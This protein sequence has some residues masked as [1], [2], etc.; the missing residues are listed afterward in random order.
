[1]GRM[2]TW[3]LRATGRSWIACRP[4][5]P[6]WGGL[7]IGVE[8]SEPKTPPLVIVN[9]PPSSSSGLSLLLGAR[10]DEVGDRLL[11]FGEAQPLGV[12]Q[13]GHDEALR[14]AD[15]D[16]DVVVVAIDDVVAADFGVER[17]LAL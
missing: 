4:R 16:A 9:V 8:R 13:H 5:T 14:A 3:P 15:G 17:G 1:M 2:T 10:G 6:L 7:T 11:D 12:A